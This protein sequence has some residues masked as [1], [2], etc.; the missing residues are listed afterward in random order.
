MLSSFS[1]GESR[2]FMRAMHRDT[3]AFIGSV[4]SGAQKRD[5]RRKR[6]GTSTSERPGAAP[7]HSAN[8]SDKWER[9]QCE[10]GFRLSRS[11][12]R[13]PATFGAP[14]CLGRV[15]ADGSFSRSTMTWLSG[16]LADREFGHWMKTLRAGESLTA[17]RAVITCVKVRWTI[18]ATAYGHAGACGRSHS[19]WSADLP[20][21]SSTSGARPGAIPST[22]NYSRSRIDAGH[23]GPLPRIDAGWYRNETSDWSSVHGDWVP[24]AKLF[25]Q[26]LEATAK[27]IRER[28]LRSRGSGSK[29]K[30]RLTV[31]RRFR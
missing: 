1:L 17:P 10:S 8:A 23:G 15:V 19:P 25:P 16:G 3:C 14:A 30:R 4:R 26:G 7:A 24:S 29:W 6:R 11:R 13:R 18:C 21:V 12:I 31:D 2:R 22:T 20:I 27:A 9:C 5:W 28:G